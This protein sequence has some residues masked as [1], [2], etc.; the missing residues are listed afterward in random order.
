L[1]AFLVSLGEL[2]PDSEIDLALVDMQR[3]QEKGSIGKIS[4][5]R[6]YSDLYKAIGLKF[7][8]YIG[9]SVLALGVEWIGVRCLKDSFLE[10]ILSGKTGSHISWLRAINVLRFAQFM[11][12]NLVVI[13]GFF[14][15]TRILVHTKQYGLNVEK[16]TLDEGFSLFI[17]FLLFYLLIV[18]LI[19]LCS[20]G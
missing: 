3:R 4:H 1:D 18:D 2:F 12:F 14:Y 11:A 17:C 20:A 15:S 9:L 10:S 7:Y 16:M 8:I 6:V 5:F 19:R 13:D